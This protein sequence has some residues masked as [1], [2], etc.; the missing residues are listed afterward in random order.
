MEPQCSRSKCRTLPLP[1]ATRNW[2][3]RVG[4]YRRITLG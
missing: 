2:S 1:F 3:D 4:F